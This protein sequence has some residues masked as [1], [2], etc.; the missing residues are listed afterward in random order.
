MER[1]YLEEA[2][3]SA[4]SDNREQPL[5]GPWQTLVALAASA[6]AGAE[7]EALMLPVFPNF[8]S[9]DSVKRWRAENL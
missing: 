4:S 3:L 9:S 7:G 5:A 2:R 6:T 8:N 1:S